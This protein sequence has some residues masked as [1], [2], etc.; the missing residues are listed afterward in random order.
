ML[1]D[2]KS[3]IEKELPELSD[4]KNSDMRQKG[5]GKLLLR[6][7]AGLGK[8]MQRLGQE[9]ERLIEIEADESK[10]MVE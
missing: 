8:K 9:V 2:P 4:R 7:F 3:L 5:S 10:E 1:E 6:E